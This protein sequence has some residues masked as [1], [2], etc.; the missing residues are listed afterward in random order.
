MSRVYKVSRV[1]LSSNSTVYSIFVCNSYEDLLDQV[2]AEEHFA[3]V[4]AQIKDDRR[5]TWWS[6]GK[7]LREVLETVFREGGP[8]REFDIWFEYV[9]E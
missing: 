4:V 2:L 9:K 3:D 5:N 1:Y 7:T 8:W 6:R